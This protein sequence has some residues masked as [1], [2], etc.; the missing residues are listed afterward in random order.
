[1]AVLDLMSSIMTGLMATKGS[2]HNAYCEADAQ[3]I[4]AVVTVSHGIL[5]EFK[6]SLSLAVLT[7]TM[8]L[9]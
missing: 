9:Y 4:V 7:H 6:I 1:M 2:L 3:L 5:E 8:T